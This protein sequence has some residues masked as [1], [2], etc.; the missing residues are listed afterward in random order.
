MFKKLKKFL[1]LVPCMVVGFFLFSGSKAMAGDA[2]LIN[3][4]DTI[5]IGEEN[6]E[7]TYFFHQYR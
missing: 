7:N 3:A 4:V 1:V 5:V 6:K 2:V